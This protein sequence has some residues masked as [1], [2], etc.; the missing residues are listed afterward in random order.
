MTT[1]SD[2]HIEIVYNERFFANGRM[3]KQ[4]CPACSM[5]KR[6]DEADEDNEILQ[7]KIRQFENRTMD[8]SDAEGIVQRDGPNLASCDVLGDIAEDILKFDITYDGQC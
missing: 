5:V 8:T 3:I 7:T 4:E 1:C 2:R 6:L